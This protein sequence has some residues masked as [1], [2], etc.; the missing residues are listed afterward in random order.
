MSHWSVCSCTLLNPGLDLTQSNGQRNGFVSM[1]RPQQACPASPEGPLTAPP[2]GVAGDA[3]ALS[4]A[5]PRGRWV[6]D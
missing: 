6:N 5:R 2:S 3:L 4:P 1:P